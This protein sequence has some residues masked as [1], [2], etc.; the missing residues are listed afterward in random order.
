MSV[1]STLDSSLAVK[2]KVEYTTM[3]LHH[4]LHSRQA[5]RVLLFLA[6]KP[7]D[8]AVHRHGLPP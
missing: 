8:F 6:P 5:G 3:K 1:H 4:H 2:N 7:G